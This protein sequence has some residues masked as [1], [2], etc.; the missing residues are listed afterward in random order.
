MT[1]CICSHFSIYTHHRVCS[2]R[3]CKQKDSECTV[4]HLCKVLVKVCRLFRYCLCVGRGTDI[5]IKCKYCL[6][7][8]VTEDVP[9]MRMCT[10][11]RID[12]HK[13]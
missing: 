8:R 12:V 9:D 3:M 10:T 11:S 6:P 2:R 13:L 7:T 1:M 5:H 4:V